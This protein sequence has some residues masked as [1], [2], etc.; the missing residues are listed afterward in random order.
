MRIRSIALL[1]SLVALATLSGCGVN[2][3]KYNSAVS[4]RVPLQEPYKVVVNIK[5]S[6][7][8]SHLNNERNISQIKEAITQDIQDNIFALP[9][10]RGA[11]KIVVNVDVKE[12]E[13]KNEP[14]G[15]LWF[16]LIYLGAPAA[17]NE[18]TA[19]IQVTCLYKDGSL[20]SKYSSEAKLTKWRGLY[21]GN[22]YVIVSKGGITKMALKQA[23]EDIKLQIEGNQDQLLTEIRKRGVGQETP[24]AVRDS[25]V[26]PAKREKDVVS[27]APPL[28][29]DVDRG[30]PRGRV[31]YRDAVAVI[32]GNKDYSCG[33]VPAVEYAK[34]DA[35][36]MRQYVTALLGYREGNVVYVENATGAEF[37][38]IFGTQEYPGRLTNMVKEGK[39]D[40][41]IYYSGHGAPDPNTR[42]G[43]FIP[44]D[45]CPDDARLNG[46]PLET[47]YENLGKLSPR[48]LTVVIDACFS[49]G[50]N[51]G[52][53]IGQ[54]SPLSIEVENP[55]VVDSNRVVLASSSGNEISSWYPEKRHGLFTYYFLKGLRGEADVDG[56]GKLTSRELFDYVSDK[57]DG[58]PYVARRLYNGRV[59]TPSL[60]GDTTF[61]LVEY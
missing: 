46:Y 30:I 11:Y 33:D 9:Q 32:I 54:A 49:G 8:S 4:L 52:M 18:G 55:A 31:E 40:V 45:C 56:N 61:V 42:Q 38:S 21:Y 57:S 1:V 7:L 19:V 23:M 60:I 14:W 58:V 2:F 39:S 12:L 44:V 28:V 16:P 27:L 10:T 6:G 25:R 43:Y 41:F 26:P 47:F 3:T 17:R 24:V 13:F 29:A 20:L 35:A 51:T 53:L 36:V 22:K 34:N 48:S 5:T 59:Q 50:S 15:L 37:R